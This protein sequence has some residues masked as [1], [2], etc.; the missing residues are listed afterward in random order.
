MMNERISRRTFLAASAAAT[1]AVGLTRVTSAVEPAATQPVEPIIDIHQHT[2][3]WGRSDAALLHHQK[4]M[5]VTHTILL[6]SGT[7]TNSPSTHLGQSNGLQAGAGPVSTCINLAR[8]HPG[9]YF[10]ASNEVPDLPGAI[11]TIEKYLKQGAVAIGEQKFNLPCDSKEMQAVYE[12]AGEYDVPITLHFQYEWYNTGFDKFEAMLKKFPKVNFVGHA[13]MF[14]ANIDAKCDQKTGY[15]HGKVTPGGLTDRYLSDYPNMH[16]DMSAGSG[17]NALIRDEDYA[18]AFIA[19]HKD[20]MIYGSDC[21]DPAGHGPTCTGSQMIS[22]IRR[23]SPNPSTIRQ[24][25]FENARSLYKLPI[26]I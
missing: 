21:P 26:P 19:R 18:R 24:L 9:T 14:W 16:A 17:L 8:S 1:V 15:P 2:N 22:A 20:R 10:F 25:L 3:Y 7:P 5:G 11:S 6:P 23:L 13:Q 12:L 4:V